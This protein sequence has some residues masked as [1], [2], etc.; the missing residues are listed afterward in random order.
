MHVDLYLCQSL[1]E[2][3]MRQQSEQIMWPVFWLDFM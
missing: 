2:I 3:F 1:I